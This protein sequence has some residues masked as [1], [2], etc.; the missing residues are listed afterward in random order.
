[1]SPSRIALANIDQTLLVEDSGT[2]EI[3]VGNSRTHTIRS[4]NVRIVCRDDFK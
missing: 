4:N 1:V 3:V 2:S